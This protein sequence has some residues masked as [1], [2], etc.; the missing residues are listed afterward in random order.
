MRIMKFAAVA[1]AFALLGTADVEA[2]GMTIGFKMGAS[3]SNVSVDP[4][5]GFD[6]K[7][8][9]A[10]TGGGFLRFPLG[11]VQLQ[12]ELMYITKGFK[13][14]DDE[15]DAEG[16]FKLSYI[17]IPVLIVLPLTQGA[18]FSPYVF[19]G[20]A[21]AFEA[22]CKIA[23]EGG[24]V[25]GDVDCDEGGD[26]IERK[27]F[28]VG[29]MFGAGFG[30]PAGPGSLLIEG[31]Y[32]FGLMNIADTDGDESLKNRSGAVLVGYSIPLGTR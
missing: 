25:S 30:I 24:G 10:F 27:K 23:F 20:P 3:F 1:A 2:Q 14:E 12:P 21:F 26:T 7:S 28:D 11:P 19:G 31:R 15:S 5:E 32:N 9:T 18:S 8:L 29:A 13:M 4:D 16:K 22:S 17:E 6:T